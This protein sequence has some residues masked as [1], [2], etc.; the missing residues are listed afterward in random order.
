MSHAVSQIATFLINS[1]CA[2]AEVSKGLAEQLE[3]ARELQRIAETLAAARGAECAALRARVAEAEA[4]R[5]AAEEKAAAGEALRRN[6]HNTILVR[7]Q[8]DP[9][10]VPSRDQR[11]L[12]H[13]LYQPC[14]TWCA[15]AH[16]AGVAE[17]GT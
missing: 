5:A 6:L 3:I 16:G 12:L 17:D 2:Q 1:A 10:H 8:P 13:T 7:S 14:T 11:W 9:S 15:P 4:A